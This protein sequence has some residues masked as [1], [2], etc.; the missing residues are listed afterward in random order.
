M[1]VLSETQKITKATIEAAWK[2]RSK[3]QR[4]IVRDKECK[5]LALIVNATSMTW[6]YAYRPRGTDPATGKRWPNKTLSLGARLREGV[7][8]IELYWPSVTA[9]GLGSFMG[10]TRTPSAAP[11]PVWSPVCSIALRFGAMYCANSL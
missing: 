6:S 11:V 1:K 2:R 3:D 9:S 10:T 5:G 8:C 7:A 4:L